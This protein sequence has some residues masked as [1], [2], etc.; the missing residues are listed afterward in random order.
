MMEEYAGF[1][2]NK[3]RTLLL[4]QK[5]QC[6]DMVFGDYYWRHD[7][8]YHGLMPLDDWKRIYA[9]SAIEIVNI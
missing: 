6:N 9:D 1:Y 5:D 2:A 8:G 4:I 7:M 3:E